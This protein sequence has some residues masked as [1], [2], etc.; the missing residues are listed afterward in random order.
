MFIEYFYVLLRLVLSCMVVKELDIIS[1]TIFMIISTCESWFWINHKPYL[2]TSVSTQTEP[3][4]ELRRTSSGDVYYSKVNIWGNFSPILW[5]TKGEGVYTDTSDD[6]SDDSDKTISDHI[7][8]I[9][10]AYDD[11]CRS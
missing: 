3:V 2:S 1:F 5:T 7:C 10:C 11:S 6:D 9:A 8:D 4:Y